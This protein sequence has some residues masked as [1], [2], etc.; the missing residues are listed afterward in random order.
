LPFPVCVGWFVTAVPIY[1]WSYADRHVWKQVPE[2]LPVRALRVATSARTVDLHARP[3]ARATRSSGC[4]PRS[5]T[6]SPQQQ[7][8][9]TSKPSSRPNCCSVRPAL[10]V[11]RTPPRSVW[12]L[13]LRGKQGATRRFR[14]SAGAGVTVRSAPAAD[15]K[16]RR[17]RA[18]A[19]ARSRLSL[20]SSARARTAR[21]QIVHGVHVL[22]ASRD[23]Q[24][25]REGGDDAGVGGAVIH[26]VLSYREHSARRG[27]RTGDKAAVGQIPSADD[28]FRA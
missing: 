10:D 27:F 8:T 11:P 9:R 5:T 15:D 28:A 12:R 19:C 22:G 18:P 13:G 21:S 14:P 24:I 3:A 7:A 17:T 23:A 2:P 1:A 25:S 26:L 4:S 16:R 20:R 6:R